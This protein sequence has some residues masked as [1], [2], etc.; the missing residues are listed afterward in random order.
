M[1]D[2][3]RNNLIK[4]GSC[5]A[6]GL[7]CAV[8]SLSGQDF[9]NLALVDQYR[10]LSDAF[11]L[12]GFFMVAAGLLIFLSNEGSFRGVGFVL[13]KTVTF[14]LPFMLKQKGETYAEYVERK[15]AKPTQGYGFLFF[16]GVGFLAVSFVFVMLYSQIHG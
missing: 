11:M 5:L 13:Q 2:R 14:L 16:C 3:V 15:T 12:P 10:V 6:A 9:F 1:S 7:A 8:W 4:Y